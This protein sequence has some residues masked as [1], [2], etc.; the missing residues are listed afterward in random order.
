MIDENDGR[1]TEIK[2]ASDMD[3]PR[4]RFSFFFFYSIVIVVSKNVK[5]GGKKVSTT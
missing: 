2:E 5:V 4:R 1:C 3:T